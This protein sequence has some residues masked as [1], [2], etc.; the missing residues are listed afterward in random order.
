MADEL[1]KIISTLVEAVTC[2]AAQHGS[3]SI[4]KS[5]LLTHWHCRCSTSGQCMSWTQ[6]D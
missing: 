5:R 3:S 4:P 2:R 1:N 6:Q